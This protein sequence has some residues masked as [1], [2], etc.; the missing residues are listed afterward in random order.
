MNIHEYRK[1]DEMQ[2]IKSNYLVDYE[3]LLKGIPRTQRG[4]F[5]NDLFGCHLIFMNGKYYKKIKEYWGYSKNAGCY[6]KNIA[7]GTTDP[8][9]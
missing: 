2:E 8:G 7:R 3:T 4:T 6:C 9:Y 1:K 5:S